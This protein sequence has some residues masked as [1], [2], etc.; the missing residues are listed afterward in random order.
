MRFFCLS[1]GKS[2]EATHLSQGWI[3]PNVM[4]VF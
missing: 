2:L 3:Y 1:E 4:H